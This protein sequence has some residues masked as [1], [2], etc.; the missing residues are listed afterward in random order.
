MR[1]L[2][3][4]W[5]L[6]DLWNWNSRR[7]CLPAWLQAVQ[8]HSR[9]SCIGS[10]KELESLAEWPSKEVRAL[11]ENKILLSRQSLW[12]H[13]GPTWPQNTL[14]FLWNFLLPSFLSFHYIICRCIQGHADNYLMKMT[15]CRC[16]L[17][18]D[19][20]N[21]ALNGTQ[22][23]WNVWGISMFPVTDLCRFLVRSQL[24][25]YFNQLIHLM[26][27]I[28]HHCC[29]ILSKAHGLIH[30]KLA[31]RSTFAKWLGKSAVPKSSSGALR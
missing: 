28:I 19:H 13:S 12:G 9:H 17:A 11:A 8:I 16:L 1:N 24:P 18:R 14:S 6:N 7:G 4:P 23:A 15:R 26:T 29:G 21:C 31:S 3:V 30:I 22:I 27:F 5:L 20:C 25:A 2:F 10:Q